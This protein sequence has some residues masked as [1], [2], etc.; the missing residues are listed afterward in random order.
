[1]QLTLL[2]PPAA[3]VVSLAEA[4]MHLRVEHDV[5]NDAIEAMIGTAE[6]LVAG[7]DGWT[8]RALGEQ[9][10]RLT[11]P[12]F[13]RVSTLRLPLPPLRSV[14]HVRYYDS[15]NTQQTFASANYAVSIAD[16]PGQ[17]DLLATIGWP[18]TFSRVDAV[19]VQFV[20]GYD[21]APAPIKH[22]VLVT[23]A[24]LYR[25]RGDEGFSMPAATRRLLAPYK[26]WG[27]NDWH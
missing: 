21:V 15:A 26:A 23:L 8:G 11:L 1:M 27:L 18:S 13:P 19:E 24:A 9:T 16:T 20:C 14:A 25:N 12:G 6:A 4:K 22:A 3:A 17:I 2:T 5:E 10:W 7:R